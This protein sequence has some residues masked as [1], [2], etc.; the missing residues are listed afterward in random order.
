MTLVR[1]DRNNFAPRLGMAWKPLRNTVVRAGYGINYNTSAYSASCRTWRSSRHFRPRQTNTQSDDG[2]AHA[3]R[4]DSRRPP[5][6]ITNNYGVDPNYRLGYVQIW[7]VDVQ[8]QISPTLI[9]NLDYTGTKGTR[10]DIVRS[11]Q[12]HGNGVLS[13]PACSRFCGRLGGGFDCQC[14]FGARPQAVAARILDWRPLHVFEITG[15]RVHRKRRGGAR[16]TSLRNQRRQDAF[17]LAAERGLSSFDQR[18]KFTA[19]YLWELPFGHERRW[20][21]QQSAAGDLGRLELERRLDHR[22]RLALH[23]PHSRRLRGCE[24]RHQRHN[25]GGCRAGEPVASGDPTVHQWFN[26]GA[27]VAPP[28]GSSAMRAA[29]VLKGRAA[30]CSIWH[31]PKSFPSAKPASWNSGRSSPMFSIRPTT[32]GSTP[33]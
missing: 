32:A 30:G 18:H 5:G 1:P 11:A 20:L 29:T 8:Q 26:T 10:L 2:T 33:S 4:M 3:C 17:D 27:F 6:S 28:S 13:S 7:N 9:M 19:D 25:A 14:L 16:D 12:P 23:S 31:S 15:Q 22:L 24:S 21:T